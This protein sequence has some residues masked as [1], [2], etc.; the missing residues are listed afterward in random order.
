[1]NQ[2]KLTW[3]LGAV[4]GLLLGLSVYSL[5]EGEKEKISNISGGVVL[6]GLTENISDV[7]QVTLTSAE[8]TTTLV[9]DGA[10]WN[11]AERANYPANAALVQALLSGLKQSER[12]V[13]KTNQPKYLERLGLT[14]R[15]VIITLVDEGANELATLKTGD[16]FLAAGGGGITTFAWDQRDQRVWTVSSLPQISQNPAY[17]LQTHIIGL[18][19]FRIK[20]IDIEITGGPSWSV[21]SAAPDAQVYSLDGLG[22]ELV[23]Q[24]NAGIIAFALT[25]ISLM[26]VALMTERELFRVASASYHT[27]DGLIVT[28]VFYEREG[29]IWTTLEARYDESV[30]L[31]DDTPMI[32]PDAPLDGA[33]EAEG[34]NALWQGRVF[35]ITVTKIAEILQS[36]EMLISEN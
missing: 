17:W 11:V 32:M 2:T 24:E 16:Q 4:A 21:F 26:D 34:L 10:G 1:M 25:E 14:D 3:G 27:F 12:L 30:L 36:R 22:S 23:N 15:A 6:E 31:S 18:S 7:N 29:E 8:D 13:A 19:P 9:F 28:L 33:A 20:R 5:I 35:L